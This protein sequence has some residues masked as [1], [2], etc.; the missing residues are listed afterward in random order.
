MSY[1]SGFT[2]KG[3]KI[4]ESFQKDIGHTQNPRILIPIMHLYLEHIFDLVLKK[5]WDESN[6]IINDRSGYSEKLKL[7]FT[8]NLINNERYDTLKAINAIRNEFVHSFNPDDK[9]IEKLTL[10][11]HGHAFTT[12]RHWIER[13]LA[14][15]IDSMSV[16]C[17]SLE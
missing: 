9:K 10:N 1:H 6:I 8:R 5:C 7:L 12:K 4:M 14:G 13:L 17:T 2:E 15:G 11:I 3:S 16:L